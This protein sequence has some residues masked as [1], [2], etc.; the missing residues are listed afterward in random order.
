MLRLLAGAPEALTDA[1]ASPGKLTPAVSCIGVSG[2]FRAVGVKFP[3]FVSEALCQRSRTCEW[4][5][6]LL[7]AGGTLGCGW[8]G[9]THKEQ[10]EQPNPLARRSEPEPYRL[11]GG[12]SSPE[13]SRAPEGGRTTQR[14]DPAPGPMRCGNHR[15]G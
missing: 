11:G 2:R 7:K 1:P 5:S 14:G 13:V 6:R 4:F 15:I 12:G 9:G 3:G 10:P 8:P